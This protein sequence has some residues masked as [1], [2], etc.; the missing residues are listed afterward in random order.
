MSSTYKSSFSIDKIKDDIIENII[1]DVTSNSKTNKEK[2]ADKT[3]LENKIKKMKM[4]TTLNESQVEINAEDLNKTSAEMYIDLLTCFGAL[5]MT[6]EDIS[7]Y[8]DSQSI[9]LNS[10]KSKIRE[11]KDRLESSRKSLSDKKIPKYVIE[12]FRSAS[13]IDRTSRNFQKDR[14]GQFFPGRC[15]ANYNSKENL[16]TLPF[17]KQDNSLKYDGK[18][19]TA[20]LN[21]RFQI[22]NGFIDL[23]DSNTKLENA[24]NGSDEAWSET[25]LSDSPIK[26]SFS[27]T[28]Q[29]D[30][31]VNDNYF[32]GIDNGAICELEIKFESINTVNE[33]TL[34]PF[35]K[36]P[37]DVIAIRYKLTDDED[38]PLIEIVTPDN[39]DET[40]KSSFT[41]EKVSFRFPDILCKNIYILINQRHY[42]R[43]TYIYDPSS[44]YKNSL[45][46]NSKNNKDNKNQMAVFK[47]RYYNRDI[48]NYSWQQVNDKIISSSDDLVN[49]LIGD[50]AKTRKVTKYEYNYGLYNIECFNNH[51]DR[52]GFYVSKPI[53]L[54]SNVKKIEITTE[55]THQLDSNSNHVTDIEYYITG[56]KN[57]T[58]SEWLP[59][60][61]VNKDIIISETLFIQGETRAYFRF[62][63]KEVYS[64]MK[65]GIPIAKNSPEY[66]LD[67]NERTGNIWCVMIFN[68]DYDAIY[69]V[70]YKPIDGSNF[71]DLS[72]KYTTSIESF[73]GTGNSYVV[74]DSSP[75]IDNTDNYCTVILTNLGETDNLQNIN[76]TNITNVEFQQ[77]SYENFDKNTSEFQF[78]VLKNTIYFNKPIPNNYIV[79]VTYRH[80]INNITTKA[81]FRRNTVKDGWLTP[82]LNEIR[83]NIETF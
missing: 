63:A 81:I 12:K 46:F 22:G 11:L 15:Y 39:V 57:P 53:N 2:E 19:E 49:I 74:L 65:N 38:E 14:Y 27:E 75:N 36:Y 5:N 28:K 13:N 61:P 41:K 51:F 58:P 40:L 30:V 23:N 82:T 44:V 59:I 69:S 4:I 32:Y 56:V 10:I 20:N 33:I 72:T 66:Y 25:I 70:S 9:Y 47:P 29:K 52:T 21:I 43:E 17:I 31:F 34:H 73:E 35:T 71:I 6:G 45:W 42:T 7:K 24:L 64:I 67:V 16:L 60:L 8:K 54:N 76:A 79:D 1:D 50:K 18:V 48:I 55:E 78:Y 80:L 26:V 68:Y 77:N 83:Y 62:E 3:L 37:I